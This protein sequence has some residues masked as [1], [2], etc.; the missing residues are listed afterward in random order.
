MEEEAAL[1]A[2]EV[3]LLDK[4]HEKPGM[5]RSVWG[6]HS[7]D[8]GGSCFGWTYEQLGWELTGGGIHI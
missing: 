2:W 8:L 5:H 7:L 4:L 6:F 3:A 1:A